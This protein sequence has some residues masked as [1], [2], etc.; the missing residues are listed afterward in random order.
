MMC[1]LPLSS[2]D[3]AD[4]PNIIFIISDDQA[5]WDYSFM[6]RND[7]EGPALDASVP[8][9][10]VIQQVAE[11]PEIDALADEGLLFTHGYTVPLCR[12]SLHSMIT[13][14]FP[15][16]NLVSGNDLIGKGDDEAVDQRI[17]FN[18]S[19]ARTL[20]ERLGYRAYQT[21]KWWGGH[22]SLGGFTEGDTQDSFS[23]SVRPPQYTGS[24]PGYV[25]GANGGGRH[26]DWGLMIG[27][28]DYVNDIPNPPAAGE[29]EINYANTVVPLTDFI[30]DCVA[31]DDPFFIWYAPFLPHNPFDPPEYLRAK[32]DALV[33]D[34]PHEDLDWT[35]KY[36]AC[37]ER[38]DGGVGA[39]LDHLDSAG[40][41]DNTMIIFICDNGWIT[42]KDT[43]GRTGQAKR[44]PADAG[45]RTPII[46]RWPDKIKPGGPIEPQLITQPVS[47]IDMVTTALAAVDLPPSPEQRGINL[48]DLDAVNARDAVYCDVYAHDMAHDEGTPVNPEGTIVA[49]FVV[50][51]GWK[52]LSY[53][54]GSEELY[55]LYNT[56][57]GDPV[58][59]FETNDLS[60]SNPA[61]ASELLNLIEAWYDE[62]KDMAWTTSLSQ[63]HATDTMATPDSLGQSFT[64]NGD[65]MLRGIS[66][67]FEH[68]DPSE[69]MTLELRQLDG[70]GAPLGTLLAETSLSPDP[71]YQA[72]L[73]WGLFPF[74]NPVTV[75]DGQQLGFLVKSASQPNIGF[76]IAYDNSGIYSGGKMYYS[77]QIDGLAWDAANLDLPFQVFTGIY[78]NESNFRIILDGDEITVSAD[79]GVKGQPVVIQSSTDLSDGSWVEI[80]SDDNPDGL[81]A[82]SDSSL[83]ERKFYRFGLSTIGDPFTVTP[84]GEELTVTN[85]EATSFTV[86]DTD[87][88]Q[89]AFGSYSGSALNDAPG[90]TDTTFLGGLSPNGEA[91][92]HD[93]VWQNEGAQGRGAAMA[94]NGEVAEYLLDLTA[95]PA[96]YDIDQIDLY[97]N[98]GTGQG[99]DEIKVTISMSLVGTPTVFDQ[100]VVSNE[101][102]DPPNETQGKMSISNIG[103]SGIAA[104]R[105]DWPTGQENGGVGYSEIDV[106]GSTAP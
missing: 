53:P 59:P 91:S 22:Y 9:D 47:V 39:I 65:G 5:W 30:D 96:G 69:D 50:K 71:I 75:T 45:S 24:R 16:Q 85:S 106:F 100:I 37:V 29:T 43:G 18:Q 23:T 55:Q 1:L 11:T 104:I 51:D 31:E 72:G 99:R 63:P 103:A 66:L 70:S 64:V 52:L 87:L 36:Y 56:A 86:S 74:A 48:M 15:H 49:R 14:T 32:Y 83:P 95:S 42:R 17:Q 12:P 89:T 94:Q 80:G 8:K 77:G 44:N 68:T 10:F 46:V 88:L 28:V 79:L 78:R 2:A 90:A 40:I 58:D 98:W 34:S 54:D 81:V 4:R 101:I 41:A 84:G 60:G 105:F 19:I 62:P 3:A 33:D 92:L 25:G 6:Y 26:G 13:G 76:N 93:G 102:Y 73:R 61:K 97:S 82:F 20:V 21:G 57:T 35:A 38:F 7:V 67:P 27:R